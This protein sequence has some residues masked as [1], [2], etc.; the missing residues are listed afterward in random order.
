MIAGA[1][2]GEGQAQARHG[3]QGDFKQSR[4]LGGELAIQKG[5][6]VTV[7]APTTNPQRRLQTGQAFVSGKASDAGNGG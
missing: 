5:R 6:G 4:V 1:S 7:L 3:W 2:E